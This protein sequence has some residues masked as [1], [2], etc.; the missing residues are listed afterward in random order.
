MAAGSKVALIMGVANP[1]SI[2]WSCAEHFARVGWKVIVTAQSTKI[3]NKAR[4]LLDNCQPNIIGGFACDV[5]TDLEPDENSSERKSTFRR[6]LDELLQEEKLSA[7]VHS[8]AFAPS[9][10]TTPLLGTTREDF[11]VA[12]EIS[13]YSLIAVARETRD[14]LAQIPPPH[15]QQDDSRCTTG[16]I[17]ALSYLGAS[18][19]IS[20]Y[21]A[22]GP[23]KASLE[24]IVRGLALELASVNKDQHSQPIRVNALSAGPLPTISAKGG[25]SGFDQMR[26]DMDRRAPL[27][28]ITNQQVA[29]T[30]EFLSNEGGSGI[31]GQ[32]IYVDGGYSI[33]GGPATQPSAK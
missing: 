20:G 26:L 2:A 18:R 1:R 19:A 12:Q 16:S 31:T 22:M 11:L 9:I 27:G 29:S 4:P 30:V 17:T 15:Q 5:M 3:L 10:K 24:S 33:V 23:A 28:N 7:V 8:L 21:N 6:R 13:A 25:I 14:L 32:T